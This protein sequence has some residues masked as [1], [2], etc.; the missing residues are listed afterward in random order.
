MQGLMSQ[1][2]QWI[3]SEVA[4][5]GNPLLDAGEAAERAAQPR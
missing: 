2:E 4:R 1:I 3:E 5:L